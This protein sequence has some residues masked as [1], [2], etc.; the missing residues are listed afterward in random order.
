LTHDRRHFCSDDLQ[1]DDGNLLALVCD[2][3]QGRAPK[4]FDDTTGNALGQF[5]K[6]FNERDRIKVGG[7]LSQTT[8]FFTAAMVGEISDTARGI[9]RPAVHRALRSVP[10]A[11]GARLQRSNT[12]AGAYPCAD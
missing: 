11:A 1:L 3:L 8:Q 4:N 7:A 2:S 10:E 6:V 5:E 12:S 9:A